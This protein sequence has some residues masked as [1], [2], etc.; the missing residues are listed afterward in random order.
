MVWNH[1]GQVLCHSTSE[2]NSIIVEFHDTTLHPSLHILNTLNHQMASLS[3]TSLA[4]A[5][6]ETPCKLVCI[7]LLS[8]G[9]K[10][11][12]TTMPECE[13]IQGI[14]TGKSFIAVA[15]DAGYLRI[16]TTM[17]TQREVLM[18]PGK[19]VCM[20]A[21]ENKLIAAYHTSDTRNKFSIM[22]IN[23]LGLTVSNRTIDIPFSQNIKLNWL[24]FSDYGSIIAHE[25]SGRV[26]S[27]NIKKNVWMPIC[28]LNEHIIGA[29]DSF[30]II[31]VSET[32]QKIRATLCRGTNYPLTNPRPI[33]REIDYSLPLC[34]I[35]IE[36]SK[37]E[38]S[39]IRSLNF[40]MESSSKL[41]VENGLKL[42][43]TALNSELESRAFEIV[44][45]IND[46]K[47]IELSSKYASQKGRMHMANK[48]LKLLN[49]FEEKVC[50]L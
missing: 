3:T 7:A 18:I 39:L 21:Y 32:C 14:A 1:V 8:S 2:E 43:S 44:E 28:D 37:I 4:L 33:L 27:Y 35:E 25:S 17:G 41:L 22:I 47:L 24:G 9:N 20:S 36:K 11:W 34:S 13:E 15:T 49:D 45:L 19:F 50:Y 38:E 6:K 42:F 40:E 16:F 48:I 31:G 23:V 5:T 12:S 46:K 10:E 29:S 30:F 26:L